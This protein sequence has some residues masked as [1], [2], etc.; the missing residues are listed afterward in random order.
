MI[1]DDPV[2]SGIC[3]DNVAKRVD[4]IAA[5]TP[6]GADGRPPATSTPLEPAR[7][8]GVVS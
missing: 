2:S 6:V 7:V 5:T 8:R 1:S 4:T 3:H